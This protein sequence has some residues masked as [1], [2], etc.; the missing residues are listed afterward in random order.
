MRTAA[1]SMK[2]MLISQFR[3]PTGVLGAV[4]GGVMAARP[5]NRRRNAWTVDLIDPQPGERVLEIG[6]GPGYAVSLVA[7]RVGAG[8]AAGVDHSPVMHRQACERNAQAIAFGRVDLRLGGLEA[9]DQLPG[10]FDA[11]MSANV[12]QFWDDPDAAFALIRRKMKPGGRLATTFQP[13]SGDV[14]EDA[15]RRMAD[16]IARSCLAAGFPVADIH[17]LALPRAPAVCVLARSAG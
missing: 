2:R 10:R 7:E 6:Y 15:A 5:S 16:R 3:R 1:V 9:L 17:E 11:V 12:A 14:S 13:R 4:A 8:L